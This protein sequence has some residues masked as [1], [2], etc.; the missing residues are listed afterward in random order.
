[1][2]LPYKHII[3]TDFEFEFGGH[4]GNPPR[5][6]CMVAKDIVTGQ[7]WR[8]WRGDFGPSPPFPTGLDSLFVAFYASAELGCF[9]ALGWQPPANVLDLFTEFRARTNG[10]D[11]LEGRSLLS[12]L[13]YFNVDGIG[14]IEKQGMRELILRGVPWSDEQ[15][16]AILDYCASDVYAL[17]RL[18]PRMLPDIDL[19]RALQRGRYMRAAA[20]MEFAGVPI[21]TDKLKELRDHWDGIKEKLI[22]EVD[23]EYGVYD[24]TTFKTTLF[25]EYLMR[26]GIP[27]PRLASGRLALDRDTFK[28]MSRAYPILA[29]LHQLRHSLSEMRLNALAVGEDGR[30]RCLLSAFGSKTGRN[31]PSNTKY[32]FGPSVWLRSLVKPEPGRAIAYIDWASQEVGIAASLSNDPLM[33]SDYQTGDPYLAFG[34]NAGIL[35][36]DA[37]KKSHGPERDALKACVLGLQYGMQEDTLAERINKPRIVARELIRAHQQRYRKFWD[38]VDNA[39]SIAMDNR[40]LRTVGG[41]PLLPCFDPSPNSVMNFPMQANGAEMLRLACSMA[42]ERGIEVHAPVHDA[43]LIGSSIEDIERDT[44]AMQEIMEEAARAVLGGF[45]IPTEAKIVR[46]PNRY[47]DKRGVAMWE[48][49]MRLLAGLLEKPTPDVDYD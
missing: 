37:T 16:A 15:R 24:G 41:W 44:K 19:P 45:N 20:A 13:Q 36:P 14:A 17:E 42:T 46:Y 32:I 43:V 31:T 2:L 34:K 11:W 47:M 9:H 35:A 27:W 3:P 10:T 33:M 21:D 23:Q 49:V 22:A 12:A 7:E 38:M 29:Q 5:P 40:P 4:E 28:D 39:I 18:L 48:R 6:V 25:E 30:N 1:M 8:V 26:R